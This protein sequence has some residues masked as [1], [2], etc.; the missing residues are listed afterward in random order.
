MLEFAYP[1]SATA[2]SLKV[3][4][5]GEEVH[6]ALL[7]V[8]Q[9]L[10]G[11]TVSYSLSNNGGQTWSPVYPGIKHEFPAVGSDLRWRAVLSGNGKTTPI[12]D[13]LSITYNHIVQYRLFLPVMVRAYHP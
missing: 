7:H 11:G 6:E 9:S 10:R 2:Q 5:P 13:S 1:L 12:V 3:S 8:Q 4:Q